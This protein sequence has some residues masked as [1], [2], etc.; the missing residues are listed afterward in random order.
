MTT[1]VAKP[2]TTASKTSSVATAPKAA[3]KDGDEEGD[4]SRR[5]TYF[6]AK[7]IKE[8]ENKK[9]AKKYLES[10]GLKDGEALL[11]GKEVSLTQ[12]TR[13]ELS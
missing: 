1:A 13:F 2:Q 8:F 6:L 7:G 5:S 3:G 10:T 12:V 11:K 4:N 9:E